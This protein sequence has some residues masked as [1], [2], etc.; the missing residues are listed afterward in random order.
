METDPH[1]ETQGD[2]KLPGS[3]ATP[4]FG[5]HDDTAQE[6]E[7]AEDVREGGGT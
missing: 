6:R 2:E 1:E 4:G 3:K 7:W 5:E